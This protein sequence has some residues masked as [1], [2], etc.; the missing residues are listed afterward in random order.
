MFTPLCFEEE[1]GIEATSFVSQK[2]PRTVAT[3]CLFNN[4]LRG[5]KL[6]TILP[7]WTPATWLPG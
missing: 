6:S 2:E 7:Q 5:W 3:S 1:S 4:F